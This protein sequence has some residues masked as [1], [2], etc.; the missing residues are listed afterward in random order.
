MYY[1]EKT[2]Q[3]I[4]GLCKVHY[5]NPVNLKSSIKYQKEDFLL[6]KIHAGGI[7]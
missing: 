7:L 3:Y 5:H 4:D 1:H 2:K 6:G